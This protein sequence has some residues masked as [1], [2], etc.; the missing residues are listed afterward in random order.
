MMQLVNFFIDIYTLKQDFSLWLP[1]SMKNILNPNIITGTTS[2]IC[3]KSVT[4]G[5]INPSS[6]NIAYM[7]RNAYIIYIPST[8]V[9]RLADTFISFAADRMTAIDKITSNMNHNIHKPIPA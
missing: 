9:P 8:N 4:A 2:F 3:S 5:L 6:A 1:S 7:I